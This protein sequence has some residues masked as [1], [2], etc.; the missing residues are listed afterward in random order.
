MSSK[1]TNWYR[2]PTPAA[3]PAQNRRHRHQANS[4]RQYHHDDPV[5]FG[6]G[7]RLTCRCGERR[8]AKTFGTT[9]R[10]NLAKYTTYAWIYEFSGTI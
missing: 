4:E 7:F 1:P 6:E 3:R 9:G 2:Q 10:P 5:V 8:G